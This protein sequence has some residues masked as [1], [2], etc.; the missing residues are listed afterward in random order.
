ME[1]NAPPVE[2]DM[3]AKAPS[4][5]NVLNKVTV[6]GTTGDRSIFRRENVFGEK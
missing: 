4:G 6:Y 3:K 5:F 2:H 1:K